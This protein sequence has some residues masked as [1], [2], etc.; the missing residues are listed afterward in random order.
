MSP[1]LQT[2][3]VKVHAVA[4]RRTKQKRVPVPNPRRSARIARGVGRGSPASKQQGVLIR[5]LCLANEAEIITD[6]ALQA[7]AKLFDQPLFDGHIKA[8]LALFRW[9]ASAL[10]LGGTEEAVED[11]L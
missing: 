2:P 11:R 1:V 4:Q 3:P 5:K 8:I 7:Y 9:E 10:P 6:D